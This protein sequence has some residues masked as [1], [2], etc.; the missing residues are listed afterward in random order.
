[1]YTK[2]LTFQKQLRNNMPTPELR[3][4]YRIRNKQLGVK[5]RRQYAVDNRILDFYSP[6]IKL[7]IEIDGES[8]FL[9]SNQYDQELEND[10]QL[11]SKHGIKVIRFLN[12]QVMHNITEVLEIIMQRCKSQS[13]PLP[14]PPPV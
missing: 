8:H 4:W 10:K 3:L 1:M 9:T 11:Y 12:N 2:Y 7:G 5:F 6:E 13:H 14:N